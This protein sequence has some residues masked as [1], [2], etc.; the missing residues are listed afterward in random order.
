MHMTNEHAI[1]TSPRGPLVV[2]YGGNAMR[3]D[4]EPAD[5]LLEEVARL[6]ADG[7]GVVLVHGGGPEIDRELARRGIASRRIEGLRVTDAA[8]LEVTEAVL[9][10]TLNKRL[11]RA[12]QALGIR[13]VGVSGQDGPTLIAERESVAATSDLGYVGAV[14]RTDPRLLCALL[15]GGFLPVV[16]PLAIANDCA[17]AYNINADLAAAAVAAMLEARAFVIVTNVARVLRDPDDPHSGID[18]LSLREA[19]A[20][21]IDDACRESMKPKLQAAIAAV[22]GGADIAYICASTP[23][24]IQGAIDGNATLIAP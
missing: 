1:P 14:A 16:A 20:F 24:A 9:C 11:V 4:R 5:P 19:S 12:F 17:H 8:T 22:A 13:A 21:V 6:H 15:A 7:S 10:A 2:K 3:S 23:G 18:R